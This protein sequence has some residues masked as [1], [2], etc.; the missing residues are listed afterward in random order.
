MYHSLTEEE[1]T[2]YTEMILSHLAGAPL[3]TI[4]AI[5]AAILE[6]LDEIPKEEREMMAI[7]TLMMMQQ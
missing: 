2:R 4:N 1:V 5:L 6:T 3:A 7:M